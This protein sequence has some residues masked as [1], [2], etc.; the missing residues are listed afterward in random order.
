[1]AEEAAR[2][3]AA[4]AGMV[5]TRAPSGAPSGRTSARTSFVGDSDV[6]DVYEDA[7]DDWVL[8][9]GEADR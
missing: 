4:A 5:L 6:D 2:T 1:M 7:A 3:A 8:T 9:T